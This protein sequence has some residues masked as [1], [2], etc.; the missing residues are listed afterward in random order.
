MTRFLILAP[1]AFS[2]LALGKARFATTPYDESI[3]SV[4]REALVAGV[5]RSHAKAG[6][7]IVSE[8]ATGR[9]LAA[10]TVDLRERSTWTIDS[11]ITPASGMKPLLAAA[12]IQGGVTTFDTVHECEQGKYELE[13][14]VYRD[15]MAFDRL[16]TSE[17][18]ARSSSICALK[19]AE[20][21]G[22]ERLR[23]AMTDFGFAAGAEADLPAIAIGGLYAA[24]LEMVQ[25]FGSIANGGRLLTPIAW[26]A[27]D[28]DIREVRTVLSPEVAGGMRAV[29]AR[30][31]EGGTGSNAR[32]ER[33]TTAGKTSSS[34]RGSGPMA[35]FIGFAPASDP[36]VV[37]YVG[38][39][40]PEGS[41]HGNGQAA[42]VFRE[43]VEAVL[44]R[45]GVAPDR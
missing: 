36:R 24:P 44:P 16:T 11:P 17:M 38:I 42:P 37:V 21:L 13:G 19:I 31:V 8:P 2:M 5:E 10:T 26:D 4:A 28:A 22:V 35:G 3:D 18:V 23:G 12:A 30:A 1:A 43:V 40:E 34:G 9:V 29:L 15:W 25:A 20:R 6:F 33:W 39:L 45:L 14:T 41:A 27:K 32:S 7:V